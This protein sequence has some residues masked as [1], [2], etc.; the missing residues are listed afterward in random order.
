MC[1]GGARLRRAPDEWAGAGAFGHSLA[2]ESL[3]SNVRRVWRGWKGT[4]PPPWS[5]RR[6]R[7]MPVWVPEVAAPCR[8][9]PLL[10]Q[11]AAFMRLRTLISHGSGTCLRLPEHHPRFHMH[12]WAKAQG[13]A[14]V[15]GAPSCFL[16]PAD[17][18]GERMEG[19]MEVHCRCRCDW[20]RRPDLAL[21]TPIPVPSPV[22]ARRSLLPARVLGS[23]RLLVSR[24]LLPL[25]LDSSSYLG[26]LPCHPHLGSPS[27]VMQHS[28]VRSRPSLSPACSRPLACPWRATHDSGGHSPI[29]P[30]GSQESL[31]L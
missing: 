6:D 3:T 12:V 7:W 19:M 20:L 11:E 22:K 23:S 10:A 26:A 16:P 2:L 4:R 31:R 14:R 29:L 1:F 28:P 8:M 15:P 21:A 25:P 13:Q 18:D 17:F 30:V 24:P 9:F 27:R 5:R